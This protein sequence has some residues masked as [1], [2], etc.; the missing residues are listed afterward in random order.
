M[1]AKPFKL[2]SPT[3]LTPSIARYIFLPRFIN[4]VKI[5]V[6]EF[7]YYI[8]NAIQPVM[9]YVCF[10][11]AWLFLIL[12]GWS[13]F[14]GAN[15]AVARSKQMHQRPCSKCRYFTN[16]FRLKCTVQPT[17]ANTEG[18]IG[19]FDYHPREDLI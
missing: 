6:W 13:L 2:V 12:L 18:A 8:I 4:K 17:I 15:D 5:I 10:C 19:C 16:D 9:P 14:S 1:G 7:V 3:Y 11:C